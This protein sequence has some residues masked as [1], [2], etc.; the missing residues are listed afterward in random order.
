MKQWKPQRK[1]RA[2]LIRPTLNF[3]D[4]MGKAGHT[5]SAFFLKMIDRAAMIK[6]I[7]SHGWSHS[8]AFGCYGP[9]LFV[10]GSFTGRIEM[11]VP[12]RL[13]DDHSQCMDGIYGLVATT[14]EMHG[15]MGRA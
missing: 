13:E 7:E 6:K 2:D 5:G 10:W 15:K 9:V 12:V 11:P 8:V 1:A 14:M 3:Y 4:R